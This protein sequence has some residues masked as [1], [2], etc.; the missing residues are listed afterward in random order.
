[1]LLCIVKY[2]CIRKTILIIAQIIYNAIL[3]ADKVPVQVQSLSEA[4]VPEKPTG[5]P[6]RLLLAIPGKANYH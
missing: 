6:L 5:G 3:S 1:M 2:E 4:Q